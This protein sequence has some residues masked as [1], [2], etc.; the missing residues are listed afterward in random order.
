[1]VKNI[2]QLRIELRAVTDLIPYDR[3]PRTHTDQQVAQIAASIEKFG[4]TN[5]ILIGPDNVVIAGH[6][7]KPWAASKP[8]SSLAERNTI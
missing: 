1:M 2:A 8:I 4:W 5:P 7:P 6:S 3:N